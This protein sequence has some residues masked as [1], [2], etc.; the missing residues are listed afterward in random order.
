MY[1]IGRL[2]LYA[3]ILATLALEASLAHHVHIDAVRPNLMLIL[4]IFVG[5]F[6]DWR[7]GLEAGIVGGLLRGAL[8][9]GS[10]GINLTMF[11]LCALFANYC[12]NKL[13]RNSALTQGTL[14]FSVAVV[15]NLVSVFVKIMMRNV[16]FVT[17][18][19]RNSFGSAVVFVSLYTALVAPLFFLVLRKL[20]GAGKSEY[21]I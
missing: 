9:S 1:R 15:F 16:D 18:D 11:S 17:A 13:Y 8:T 14:C 6:S 21:S 20:L 3:V 4:V 5:L 12:R 19:V 2:R 10:V 7:E